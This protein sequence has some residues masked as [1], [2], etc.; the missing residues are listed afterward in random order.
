MNKV[1][2]TTTIPY[3][4]AKPH[5]GFALELVQ[6][7]AVARYHRLLGHDVRLQTGTDENAFKNVLAARE[8]GVPTQQWVDE[9]SLAFQKLGAS[10]NIGFDDFIRTT[11]DRHRRGVHLFWRHLRPG[12]VYRGR[13]TGL[14]CVGCEDF[15]TERDLVGGCCPDHGVPPSPCEE[16]NYFFRLSSYQEPIQRLIESK[17]INVIP[18]KRRNEV[19]AFVRRG[20]QDICISRSAS[21]SDGWGIPVPG[22]P[23]QVIYVW[24]DAL[25]NYICGPGYGTG[26]RWTE[27]WSDDVRKI[28][29]IGKN[30]WKF[31]AVYWP[32]LLL[33]AGLPLPN[34]IVVHGFLTEDG[35]KIS[36]SSSTG[37]DPNRFID[38]Y[39]TEAL[40]YYLL[41]A[42]SPF[43]DGDFSPE[44][45]HRIYHSDLANG[46][47]NLVCRL[48][49]LGR[50]IN[51]HGLDW[52]LL[53]QAPDGF[54]E[55]FDKY[56]TDIALET[57]WAVVERLNQKIDQTRPWELIP[58]QETEKLR[59]LLVEWL[60]QLQAV[61]FWVEPFLPLTSER[62][63]SLLGSPHLP[64]APRLFPRINKP[65]DRSA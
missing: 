36:K 15:L 58:R 46:L 3:V 18:I 61:A 43:E 57:L 45:L 64:A 32:G 23:S 26:E 10:L 38:E 24:I 54:H 51:L 20:L 56:R 42:V 55:A 5:V 41:G 1:Y 59:S 53:P 35:R 34:Q 44:R 52:P 16:E 17:A 12:D 22:D 40:R 28:H 19:L 11:E 4:N 9:N 33:S 21:R 7:D 48:I 60:R 31:H 29:F 6:A 14:Y 65:P 49:T 39:G 50:K 13:Y 25:V 2:V 27:W 63:L 37:A 30:V 62:L 8:H 47:G